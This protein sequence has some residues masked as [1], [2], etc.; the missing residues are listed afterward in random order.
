MRQ[1]AKDARRQHA[2]RRLRYAAT[3][4]IALTSTMMW[5]YLDR[6]RH[7]GAARPASGGIYGVTIAAV[8]T[9]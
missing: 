2:N 8:S 3:A 9:A 1:Y 6:P 7:S 4:A 5:A